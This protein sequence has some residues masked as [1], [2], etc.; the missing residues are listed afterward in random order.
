MYMD[1]NLAV[2]QRDSSNSFN[3]SL[4]C[5]NERLMESTSLPEITNTEMVGSGLLY[6]TDHLKCI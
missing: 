5:V 4:R 1:Q 2:G 6:I 3:F